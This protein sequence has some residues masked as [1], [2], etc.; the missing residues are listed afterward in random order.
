MDLKNDRELKSIVDK[1]TLESTYDRDVYFELASIKDLPTSDEKIAIKKW[2]SRLKPCYKI[3][4]ESYAYEPA[5]VAKWSAV[6]DG[7]QQSLVLEF[8][9][10]E[11]QLW[12]VCG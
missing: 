9:Q 2:A 10:G 3:K 7:E 5:S 11:Y 12:A 4:A 1:V 8:S 6:K